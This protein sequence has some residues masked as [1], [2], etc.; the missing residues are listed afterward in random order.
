MDAHQLYYTRRTRGGEGEGEGEEEEEEEVDGLKSEKAYSTATSR[1]SGHIG[2][3]IVRVC[4]N[5]DVPD[6][7]DLHICSRSHQSL[8]R[9]N[10]RT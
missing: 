4:C 1:I 2:V 8:P 3:N 5:L 7:C 9:A 10:W 6:S